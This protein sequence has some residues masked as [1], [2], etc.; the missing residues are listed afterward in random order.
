MQNTASTKR[1]A[2]TSAAAAPRVCIAHIVACN[3]DKM[4]NAFFMLSVCNTDNTK[5]AM[6]IGRRGGLA[7][8]RGFYFPHP[9][10]RV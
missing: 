3:T 2:A 7:G 9:P 8:L 5:N 4:K 6:R 10:R 1:R